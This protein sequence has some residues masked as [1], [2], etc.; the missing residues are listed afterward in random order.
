MPSSAVTSPTIESLAKEHQVRSFDCG[1]PALNEY[2]QRFALKNSK[3]GVARTFVVVLEGCRDVLG[4]YTLSAG[5]I[6][7]QNLPPD[8]AKGMPKYPVPVAR[9]GRMGVHKDQQGTGLGTFLLS[10]AM[11][12]VAQTS[13]EIGIFALIIDAK[14]EGVKA[15]Y[16]KFGFIEFNDVPLSLF[17]PVNTILKSITD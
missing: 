13:A 8:A 4:F 16:R 3:K 14:N 7:F 11:N 6:T 2:L 1:E 12:R 10:D 17:L 9:L 15:F 5:S